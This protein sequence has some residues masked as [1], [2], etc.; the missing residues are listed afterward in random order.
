MKSAEA[1]RKSVKSSK[2]ERDRQHLA[3]VATTSEY[4]PDLDDIITNSSVP[5]RSV[6]N[7]NKKKIAKVMPTNN[8]AVRDCANFV[9]LIVVYLFLNRHF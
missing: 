5:R 2:A 1:A 8:G 3:A 9:N 4:D 7:Y 6:V